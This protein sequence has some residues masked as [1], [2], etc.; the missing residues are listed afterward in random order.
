MKIKGSCSQ[1]LALSAL[2]LALL[3]CQSAKKASSSLKTFQAATPPAQTPPAKAPTAPAPVGAAAT[4][5]GAKAKIPS[6]SRADQKPAAPKVDA[7]AGL[8]ASAEKEYQAG[9]SEFAAGHSDAAKQHFDAAFNQ[10]QGSPL[11]LH[12]DDR[13]QR[14]FERV[15]EALNKLDT[16]T[17][18]EGQSEEKSEP[19]PIDEANAVNNYP[20]DPSLKAKA[21]AEIKAT[22]SDLPLMMT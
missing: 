8:V 21:A 20:V 3:G 12:S 10:L 22:H 4:E 9:N 17:Q 1:I 18:A 2:L 14:E 11:E 7:V 16:T 6:P 15:L 5:P 13:F 19:A